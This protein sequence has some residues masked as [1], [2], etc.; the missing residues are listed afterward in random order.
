MSAS[1]NRNGKDDT[2]VRADHPHRTMLG[3]TQLKWLKQTLLDAQGNGIPWKIIAISLPIDQVGLDGGKSWIGGYRAERNQLL[4]FIADHKIDNVVFITTDDHQNR[5][6]EV[7][8]LADPQNPKS[9]QIVPHAFTI[10][11]GPIGAGGTRFNYRPQ[12]Y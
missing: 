9:W 3:A 12:L 7:T 1:K 8:Y 5:I 2:G 4:K 11:A 10:V 6:N